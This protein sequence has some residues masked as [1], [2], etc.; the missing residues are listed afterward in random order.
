MRTTIWTAVTWCSALIFGAVSIAA[1]APSSGAPEAACADRL[2]PPGQ[3]DLLTAKAPKKQK[4]QPKKDKA[5][6]NA[7]EKADDK[8]RAKPEAA[9]PD[10]AKPDEKGGAAAA[11][12]QG[13]EGGPML[14]R[15]NRLEFDARLIQGQLAKSG[16][17]FLFERAPRPLPPLLKL[18]RSY[19]RD[20]VDAE[21][22]ADYMK[23]QK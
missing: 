1:A 4:A 7:R 5:K 11:P 14:Q 18:K 3:G 22:G 2:C 12:A 19:L 16:A 6:E 23:P 21:L 20:I 8:A 17:I 10:A 9:K 15:S 13:P